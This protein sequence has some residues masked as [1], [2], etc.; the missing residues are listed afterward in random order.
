MR[1]RIDAAGHDQLARGIHYL[2]RISFQIKS[3]ADDLF[4]LDQNIRLK[5]FEGGNECSVL[6][7]SVHGCVSCDS[8]V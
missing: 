2:C 7:Q 1:M 3:D 4:I 6:Y 8:R 5:G